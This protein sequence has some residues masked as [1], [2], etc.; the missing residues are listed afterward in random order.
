M[1]AKAKRKDLSPIMEDYLKAIFNLGKIKGKVNTTDLSRELHVAPATITQTIKRLANLNLVDHTPY[2][3]VTLTRAG[4]R[5]ALEIIRHHRLVEKYL[6][7]VLHIPLDRVHEEAER[8]EHI[9]SEEVETRIAEILGNPK[10]DPHGAPIPSS[11]LEIEEEDLITL[12]SMSS[13]E[14]GIV[15]EVP[16][17]DPQLLRYLKQK[18][19]LPDTL[20]IFVDL[21]PYGGAVV[22]EIKGEKVRVGSYAAKKILMKIL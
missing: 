13:G 5:I 21:E 10:R 20:L 11:E 22:V 14:R 19:L 3:G 6:Y 1:E 9:I 7:D 15:R 12:D 2:K 16:D 18:G 17:E 8:W 4:E